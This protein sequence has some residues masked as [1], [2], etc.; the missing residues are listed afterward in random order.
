MIYN[1]KCPKGKRQDRFSDP[2][3]LQELRNAISDGISEA[4]THHPD[5]IVEKAHG[6]LHKR[7]YGRIIDAINDR[8]K[9]KAG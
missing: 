1:N 8:R 2:A 5:W 4:I 6:S 3:F 9:L 7:I